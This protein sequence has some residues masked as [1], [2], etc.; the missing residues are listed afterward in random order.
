[1]LVL[2]LAYKRPNVT[3]Q[4][5]QRTV[6]AEVCITLV[7]L[8]HWSCY[9]LQA[10]TPARLHNPGRLLAAQRRSGGQRRTRREAGMVPTRY[11]HAP[12]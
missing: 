8:H 5:L 11:R 9:C 2:R 4:V 12:V 1:M 6:P 7:H 3:A 10:S